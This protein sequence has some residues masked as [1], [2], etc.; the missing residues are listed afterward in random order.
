MHAT[1]VFATA[2]G[3]LVHSGD[4]E[5]I[6]A[7]RRMSNFGFAGGRSAEGPGFN[8]K[9]PE[10]LGL[11]ARAKLD[12]IEMVAAHR[13]KLDAVYRAALGGFAAE[14]G[15]E[16]QEL[17]GSRPALQFQSLLLPRA[18]A[19]HRRAIIDTLAEQGIG[20]A[21]YFSPHLGEQPWFRAHGV[22]EPLP[23]CDDVGARV[24]S[25]PVTDGMTEADVERV[26]TA[27]IDAVDRGEQERRAGA[28][29]RGRAGGG[30]ARRGARARRDR[31]LCDH[32]GQYRRDLPHR[33]EGQ[34]A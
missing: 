10:V 23:V 15:F 12:E 18:F 6:A 9:L 28:A 34:R 16:F 22:S 31:Q 4:G 27:L 17:R 8:A 2:E 30:R 11:A 25:L 3:G 26:C 21:H 24:L 7:L 20:A 29:G 14:K 19:G 13:M 5:L 33:R 1:K 32:V